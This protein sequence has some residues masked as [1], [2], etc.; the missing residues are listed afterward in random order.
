MTY[1]TASVPT[2]PSGQI[3]FI[4][5]SNDANVDPKKPKFVFSQQDQ[6]TQFKYYNPQVHES[7]FN[8]PQFAKK[9]LNL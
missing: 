6:D 7:S 9:A 8:L 2:Y 1:A 5:C 4:I 3:G